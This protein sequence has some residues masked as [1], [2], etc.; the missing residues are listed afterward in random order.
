MGYKC[1]HRLNLSFDLDNKKL[2]KTLQTLSKLSAKPTINISFTVN[3]KN[4]VNQ[5]LLKSATENAKRIALT[6]CE[7]SETNLG[8]LITIN[9]NWDEI[10][11]VSSTRFSSDEEYIYTDIFR[12]FANTEPENINVTDT[13]AFVWEIQ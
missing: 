13:V 6:L 3:D 2:S 7:S 5:Q 12:I 11:L 1:T 10:N 8:Q 4:E 9:Y